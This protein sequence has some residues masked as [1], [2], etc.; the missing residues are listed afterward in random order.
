VDEAAEHG[1][2]N[3]T[4]A[5]VVSRSGVSRRTFYEI[6]RDREDCFLA[7]FDDAIDQ[8]AQR[9]VPP[10]RDQR[11][12]SDGM[13]E[14]LAALLG[15]FE[16]A[17]GLGRLL[18][19]EALGAGPR[20]L[21]RRQRVIET[22][23]LAVD[24]GASGAEGAKR[25]PPLT[26]EGV[27]GAVLSVLHTRLSAARPAGLV[28]LTNTLM[29]MVVLPYKGRAAADRELARPQAAG[30]ANGVIPEFDPLRELG[31]RLTYRTVRVLLAV[32]ADPGGSNRTIAIGSGIADQGQIS[33]LL[34]RLRG[35]GLI[36]NR[37]AVAC[38]G[39][40]NAWTLTDKGRKVHSA[41]E[42][43]AA[44]ATAPATAPR[45]PA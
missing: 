8:A 13:R 38:R 36:E 26:A 34:A 37:P 41:L 5:H 33:K 7:A 19:V 2:S 42:G 9:V 16:E 11:Q 45:S 39:E 18:V 44:G 32:A 15:L 31:M 25:P 35:L 17:P 30:H 20:A 6:F 21:E 40:P 24:Q 10:Y 1:A 22:L 29:A 43:R 12:W 3:V 28:E 27:V 4:V 23:S 14:G